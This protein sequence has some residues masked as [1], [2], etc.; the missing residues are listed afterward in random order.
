MFQTQLS[1]PSN[2]CA[3]HGRKPP[4]FTAFWEIFVYLIKNNDSAEHV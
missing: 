4:T 2:K 1:C 3:E